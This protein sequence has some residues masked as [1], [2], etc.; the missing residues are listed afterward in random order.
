M[1]KLM[2]ISL[3]LFMGIV[4]CFLGTTSSKATISCAVSISG[5]T[6]V[7]AGDKFTVTVLISNLQ[8]S[9]GIIAMDATLDYDKSKLTYVSM[10]NTGNW[11]TPS[12]NPSNG[13]LVTDRSE[14]GTTSES[15][16]RITF[17]V[18]EGASGNAV[19]NLNGIT[20]A[21]GNEE[22]TVSNSSKTVTISKIDNNNGNN[23]NNSS[24]GIGS[25]NKNTNSSSGK[26]TVESSDTNQ[27]EQTENTNEVNDNQEVVDNQEELKEN[28]EINTEVES[29]NQK[30][31][32]EFPMIYVYIGI[33]VVILI[34]LGALVYIIISKKNG[35]RG[36]KQKGDKIEIVNIESVDK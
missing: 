30:E 28:H 5:D 4:I 18:N 20:I 24:A 25:S 9:R 31:E 29:K 1:N 23:S 14:F 17:K 11:S 2:K 6:S 33:A 21:D 7:K 35:M 3:I 27:S 12:Y 13:K 22:N 16:F 19:I 15:V 36:N 26:N 34:I 8:T 32:K 10:S